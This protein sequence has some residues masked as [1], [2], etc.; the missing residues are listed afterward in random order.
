MIEGT[1]GPLSSGAEMRRVCAVEYHTAV[2]NDSS[3]FGQGPAQYP[4]SLSCCYTSVDFHLPALCCIARGFSSPVE[5]ILSPTCCHHP[6]PR[7]TQPMAGRSWCIK[8]TD[9]SALWRDNA[10]VLVVPHLLKFPVPP[11][12]LAS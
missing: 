10:E 7:T 1:G 6:L 9:P 12:Q 4:S 5:P 8:T 11:G 2:R 3:K